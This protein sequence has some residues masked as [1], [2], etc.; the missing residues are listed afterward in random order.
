MFTVERRQF[1]RVPL[2][3]P[4]LI[5]LRITDWGPET[6]L[7]ADISLGGLQASFT[8]GREINWE[9]LLGRSVV[10]DSLPISLLTSPAGENLRGSV[11]WI[12]PRRCGVRFEQPLPLSETDL[13]LAL[14]TL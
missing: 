13:V 4:C 10:V 6:T 7:L 9:T 12:S 1:A 8:P 11:S 2:D 14:A 5:T 3:A